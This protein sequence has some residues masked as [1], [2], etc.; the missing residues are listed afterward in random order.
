MK[1]TKPK[2][3]T[4][5]TK[6]TAWTRFRDPSVRGRLFNRGWSQQ[7]DFRVLQSAPGPANLQKVSVN[8]LM[9]RLK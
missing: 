7:S 9:L 4:K 6:Q 5:K 8:G 1:K 3:Q 2:K